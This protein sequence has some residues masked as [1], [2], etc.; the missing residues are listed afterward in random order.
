MRKLA[1]ILI[2]DDHQLVG[3]GTKNMLEQEP[4]FE[5]TYHLEIE[6][7]LEESRKNPFDVYLF[8]MHMPHY[9]GLELAKDILEFQED[10]KIILYT[11][12][13]YTSK[14]NLLVDLGISGIISK[15]ASRDELVMA[16]RAALNGFALIPVSLL[17][18]LRLSD[19]TIPVH[20]GPPSSQPENII[21]FTQKEI[22]ILE[23]LAKGESNKSIAEQLFMSTR[24][25]EYNLT[26]IY[27][28]LKVQT[29]SEA[30]AEA[31]RRGIIHM[32]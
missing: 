11:G 16:V 9:S 19:M 22:E 10:A 25:V 7:A 8:D 4:D 2:V 24:A 20:H 6:K 21:S 28:K 26:K 32:T 13:E 30:V 31:L 17:K 12:F 18:Q 29:R 15:S 14:F 5:V 1:R 23:S 27:K 3:E